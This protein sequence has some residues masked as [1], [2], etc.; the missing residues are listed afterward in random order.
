MHHASPKFPFG[1]KKGGK[2]EGKK[3]GTW[4]TILVA[5]DPQTHV[6]TS[7]KRNNAKTCRK[8]CKATRSIDVGKHS[9]ILP[10]FCH[11]RKNCTFSYGEDK[12][13]KRHL[14]GEKTKHIRHGC[15]RVS[16]DGCAGAAISGLETRI[17]S[18]EREDRMAQ[19]QRVE[20]ASSAWAWK[21][22]L[23]MPIRQNL[24][25]RSHDVSNTSVM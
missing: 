2:N 17:K 15:L 9:G 19:A 7:I 12:I 10:T 5:N 24:V 21:M 20:C 14:R 22:P 16:P 8:A 6:T 11:W 25:C 13:T 1:A 4:A 23:A 3:G 18:A